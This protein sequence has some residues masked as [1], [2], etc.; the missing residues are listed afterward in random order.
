MI[1]CLVLFIGLSLVLWM[2]VLVWLCCCCCLFSLRIVVL[3]GRFLV[4]VLSWLLDCCVCFL[5]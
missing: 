1:R 5:R 3:I 4:F 2:M